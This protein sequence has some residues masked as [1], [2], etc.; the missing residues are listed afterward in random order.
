M[1]PRV[2]EDSV[3]G[4]GGHLICGGKWDFGNM[5]LLEMSYRGK[6]LKTFDF[7]TLQ[8]LGVNNKKV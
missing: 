4:G 8:I 7:L 5:S 6:T 1:D 2:E 3:T